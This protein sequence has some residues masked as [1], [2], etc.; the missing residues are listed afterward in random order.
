[1]EN[2]LIVFFVLGLLLFGMWRL[3]FKKKKIPSFP[4]KWRTILEKKVMF[5]TRLLPEEK[6]RFENGI[7][8]F[9]SNIT[10]TG[11]EIPIDDTDRLLV[12]SSAVIPLFGFPGWEFRNLNEVLLYEDAFSEDYQT[13]GKD[14]QILGMVGSGAMNRMMVLSKPA[15]H[16]GFENPEDDSNVGIHEFI[17]LLDKADGE[18]NGVPAVIMQHQFVIPWIKRVHKEI[19]NIRKNDTDFNPYGGTN[20]AEFL[21]VIGE[22][23]F[24]N[25]H[26]LEKNHPALYADLERIFNQ[27]LG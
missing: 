5:Y 16:E 22:Y 19:N 26:K 4:P 3:F 12:A 1:M 13:E 20:E 14:R 24:E 7:N 25:P 17:H 9:L 18:T 27:K 8:K 10:I 2:N 21:S 23:F 15:L 11:V 6:I